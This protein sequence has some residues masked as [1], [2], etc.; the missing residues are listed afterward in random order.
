MFLSTGRPDR[1]Y[2]GR[3]VA[4]WEAR[5]AMAVRVK[6][7]YH[8]EET[9]PCQDKLH[10]PVRHLRHCNR[11]P[12]VLSTVCLHRFRIPARSIV[13]WR[14]FSRHLTVTIR[15]SRFSMLL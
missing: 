14:P 11:G 7:F 13:N 1:P 3:I 8:P 15:S 12:Y 10:Y 6:W 2:I 5:G 9:V 4:L